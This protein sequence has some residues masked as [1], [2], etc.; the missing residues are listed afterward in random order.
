MITGIFPFNKYRGGGATADITPPAPMSFTGL[1]Q[2]RYIGA[3]AA[4][5]FCT[6]VPPCRHAGRLDYL[7]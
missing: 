4:A 3:G 6:A 7:L 5:G 2:S 1:S